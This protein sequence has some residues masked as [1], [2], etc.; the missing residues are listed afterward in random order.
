M[1]TGNGQDRRRR[2]LAGAPAAVALVGGA[3]LVT[4]LFA[5]AP[6]GRS[7]WYPDAADA[8]F[9]A[10]DFRTAAV[11]YARLQQ[12]HPADP[13]NTFSLA[14]SLDAIGQVDAARSL[15]LRLAPPDAPGGYPPAHLR[16][17]RQ[18][19]A[20]DRP[21]PAAM[22]DAQRHLGPVLR[23]QPGDP[24]VNFWLAVLCAARGR[25]ELVPGPAG[26][27]GSLRD[28]LAPRLAGIAKAQGNAQQAETW[29]HGG[30]GG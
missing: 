6:A 1:T 27:A 26:V 19:L 21:T 24:E 18:D 15:L 2:W 29:S 30:G 3:G 14:R 8:A 16:I 7:E 22:D 9:E 4:W 17:V 5:A 25:W 10:G 23:A 20:G 13:G 12:L 11:C 28:V